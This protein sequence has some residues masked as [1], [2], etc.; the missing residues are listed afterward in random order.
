MWNEIHATKVA[1]RDGSL[2]F[3]EAGAR[4]VPEAARGRDPEEGRRAAV[5]LVEPRV[6]VATHASDLSGVRRGSTLTIVNTFNT[7]FRAALAVFEDPGVGRSGGRADRIGLGRSGAGKKARLG[8]TR[9]R[10][11]TSL[12]YDRGCNPGREPVEMN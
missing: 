2:R 9:L 11:R 4:R 12:I 6:L 7:R 10:P 3:L 8:A 1:I 5:F